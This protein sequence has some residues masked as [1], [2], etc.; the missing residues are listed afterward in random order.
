LGSGGEWSI[1]PM[2]IGTEL[3]L[4]LVQ[5]Q[6]ASIGSRIIKVFQ[7]YGNVEDNV[8]EFEHISD[9]ILF[10]RMWERPVSCDGEVWT[11]E[12][13]NIIRISENEDLPPS[14]I[15]R[16]YRTVVT[17]GWLNKQGEPRTLVPLYIAGRAEF[18]GKRYWYRG[19]FTNY[20]VFTAR[21][22]LLH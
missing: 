5:V 6:D 4:K 7:Y 9:Y 1:L 21:T 13:F 11:D 12:D 16:N 17:Y 20:Q 18:N 19:R 10:K 22:K 3:K 2:L 15:W 8:C 14:A